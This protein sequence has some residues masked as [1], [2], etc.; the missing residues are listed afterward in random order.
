MTWETIVFGEKDNAIFYSV[1]RTWTI[2]LFIV[3]PLVSSAP[4]WQIVTAKSLITSHPLS[5]QR[6]LS[7]LECI[8]D[9]QIK[10]LSQSRYWTALQTYL[11]L[12]RESRSPYFLH[13]FPHRPMQTGDMKIP[14]LTLVPDSSATL[15]FNPISHQ[16]IQG[17]RFFVHHSHVTQRDGDKNTVT[18]ITLTDGTT[19]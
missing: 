3:S 6:A 11:H 16:D 8:L 18:V 12:L 4:Q 19:R 9:F 15:V 14:D 13:G 7:A 5:S 2:Q 17:F 1:K 10:W